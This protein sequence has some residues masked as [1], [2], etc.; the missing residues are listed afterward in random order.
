MRYVQSVQVRRH[1]QGAILDVTLEK[2]LAHRWQA[3]LSRVSAIGVDILDVG[4]GWLRR[5]GDG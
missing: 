5:R 4:H 2:R 1:V 3:S